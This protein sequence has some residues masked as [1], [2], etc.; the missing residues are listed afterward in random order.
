MRIRGMPKQRITPVGGTVNV[1]G[2]L[3][4]GSAGMT[5]LN[6]IVP[7]T[8]GPTKGIPNHVP[9]GFEDMGD[10]FQFGSVQRVTSSR[11]T[12]NTVNWPQSAQAAYKVMAPGGKLQMN[13]WTQSQLEVDQVINAFTNAGF[14]DVKNL[15]RTVGS[16]TV[17]VG[18][19]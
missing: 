16:G 9:A 2:G 11:L 7:G 13:V 8:G 18:V 14:R 5:N 6:P 19:K 17:I 3:E 10:I 12:F 15:T 1:G 4:K